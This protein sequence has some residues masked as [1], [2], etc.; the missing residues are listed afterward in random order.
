MWPLTRIQ[1]TGPN[2]QTLACGF[3]SLKD[4]NTFDIVLGN[5]K[6]ESMWPS[7]AY[8]GLARQPR[9]RHC[10]VTADSAH[11]VRDEARAGERGDIERD[12]GLLLV[13]D[14][15]KYLARDLLLDTVKV[16]GK[17][18]GHGHWPG[19]RSH[20]GTFS[21]STRIVIDAFLYRQGW[22]FKM[23]D[24]PQLGRT[25]VKSIVRIGRSL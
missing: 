8:S 9:H 2:G 25:D 11:L 12:T 15:V 14:E 3:K 13:R 21:M 6:L 10:C 16:M 20:S 4:P 17:G 23:L 18:D 24:P 19:T 7:R 5:K 22:G 1:W